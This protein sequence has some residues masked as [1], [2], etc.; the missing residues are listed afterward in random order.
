[1]LELDEALLTFEGAFVS[2]SARTLGTSNGDREE[3]LF[4]VLTL[5]QSGTFSLHNY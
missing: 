5:S 1:M 4:S 2:S 3:Q